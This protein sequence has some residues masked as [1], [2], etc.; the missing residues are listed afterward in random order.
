MSGHMV[1]AGLTGVASPRLITGVQG[2]LP[3]PTGIVPGAQTRK[4]RPTP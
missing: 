4:A 3:V 1:E 2:L